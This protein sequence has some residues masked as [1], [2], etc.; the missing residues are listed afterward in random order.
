M[1]P[2][3]S[4]FTFALVWA[5]ALALAPAACGQYNLF[6]CVDGIPGESIGTNHMSDIDATAFSVGVT[7]TIDPVT[8]EPAGRADFADLAVT[9]FVDKASPLLMLNCA[10]G[11][12]IPNVTLFA[13]STSPTPLDYYKVA[14]GNVRVTGVNTGGTANGKPTETVTFYY[15]TIEIT[16][17][18]RNADG[19]AGTPIKACWKRSTNTSC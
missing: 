12:L 10:Q 13:Q 9:K 14:L 5:V 17:T 18:P 4:F 11:T 2:H 6:L 19:S 16:Y 7:M 3:K 15:D 8:G 1:K